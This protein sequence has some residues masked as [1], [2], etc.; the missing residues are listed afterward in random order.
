MSMCGCISTGDHW[1]LVFNLNY[2]R[3]LFLVELDCPASLIET[4]VCLLL[5]RSIHCDGQVVEKVTCLISPSGQTLSSHVAGTVQMKCYLS[6]MPDCKFGINDKL[7]AGA[8]PV[9]GTKKKKKTASKDPIAIDDLTFHQCVRLGKFDS[10]RSI[11]FVPPDGEFELM[12]YRI[13]RDVQLP[14]VITPMIQEFSNVV[15]MTIVVKGD[16]A[17]KFMATKVMLNI[18]VS[19]SAATVECK[20]KNGKAK[21]KPGSNSVIWKMRTFNGGKTATCEVKV[22]LLKTAK[23][24]ESKKK[25]K[26]PIS[27]D[28]EV[29]FAPSGLQVKYLLVTERKLGYDDAKVMKWV[30]YL[31]S[32]GSYDARY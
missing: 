31:G 22:T 16:F 21:Y 15:D 32:S 27:I 5:S 17:Q 24:S 28:F 29:P 10:T 20:T 19:T 18:P 3:F 25:A 7:V 26:P 23:A 1:Y 6:G 30:R 11:S 8:K 9:E 14:F 12:K 13:T 4:V 2:V